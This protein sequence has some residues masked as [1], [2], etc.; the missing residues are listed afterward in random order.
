M[1]RSGELFA[2]MAAGELDVLIHR[3]YPLGEAAAAHRA[4]AGRATTGKLL[5]IP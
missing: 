4:L 3:E 2:W 1:A 5:L